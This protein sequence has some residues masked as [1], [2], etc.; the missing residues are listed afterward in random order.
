MNECLPQTKFSTIT[1]VTKSLRWTIVQGE[2]LL[3]SVLRSGTKL[4]RLGVSHSWHIWILRI[5]SRIIIL[6]FHLHCFVIEK[7]LIC[8]VR[9]RTE[10]KPRSQTKMNTIQESTPMNGIFQHWGHCFP[11]TGFHCA[12]LHMADLSLQMCFFTG[13][14]SVSFFEFANA[15][16]TRWWV[17]E[18]TRINRYYWAVHKE[19]GL[20]DNNED[21]PRSH[22]VWYKKFCS[23]SPRA[24]E[25]VQVDRAPQR[26]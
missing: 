10:G 7:N 26:W 14:I 17:R 1:T 9:R 8:S 13:N 22:G 15:K 11:Y 24:R 5:Q 3:K 12:G 19:D 23:I 18:Q 2:T 21:F 16:L 25:Q 20:P 6:C 4:L